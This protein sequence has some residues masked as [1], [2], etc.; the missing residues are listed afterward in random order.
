MALQVLLLFNPKKPLGLF[1]PPGRPRQGCT[2]QALKINDVAFLFKVR[3]PE[4]FKVG[5]NFDGTT[6]PISLSADLCSG[7]G[8]RDTYGSSGWVNL[9]C[10]GRSIL[11][12]EQ[13]E[14]INPLGSG[15]AACTIYF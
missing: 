9:F 8:T 2:G 15:G 12:I 13:A 11:F 6:N 1:C 10:S 7:N 5:F 14:G 4:S 3:I